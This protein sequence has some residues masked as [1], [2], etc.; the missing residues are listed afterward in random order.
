M[1]EKR[2]K[3]TGYP[4]L[5][6]ILDGS[7]PQGAITELRLGNGVNSKLLLLTLAGILGAEPKRS[8]TVLYKPFQGMTF[9]QVRGA[10]GEVAMIQQPKGTREG[11]ADAL[12]AQVAKLK[13]KRTKIV[14]LVG[15]SFLSE[16]RDEDDRE[17]LLELMKS[18]IQT[19]VIVDTEEI[20]ADSA[21]RVADISLRLSDVNG[22]PLL[23]AQLPWTEYF[24]ITSK[25]GKGPS[26]LSLVPMV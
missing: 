14:A 16:A 13:S 4:E 6:A 23:Q 7:L 11:I 19:T 2:V 22:T 1:W 3:S 8:K 12:E 18:E 24:A 17:R 25:P 15:S 9:D 5:D 10:I 21:S 26:T 20:A